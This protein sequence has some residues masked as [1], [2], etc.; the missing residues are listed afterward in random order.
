MKQF[1]LIIIALIATILP[2]IANSQNLD[3]IAVFTKFTKEGSDVVRL[4]LRWLKPGFSE[5]KTGIQ[6]FRMELGVDKDYKLLNE[7]P[8]K[9]FT[10]EDY[11]KMENGDSLEVLNQKAI[12]D[13]ISKNKASGSVIEKV[14]FAQNLQNEYGFYFL[15]TTRIR[16]VSLSSG[17]EYI[18]KTAVKDRIYSYKVVILND[19]KSNRFGVAQITTFEDYLPLSELVATNDEKAVHFKWVQ[20]EEMNP[21][22]SYNLEK[23]ADGVQFKPI[24]NAPFY[25]SPNIS[26]T[27]STDGSEL[28]INFTTDSVA[29]NYKPNFYRLVG[30]DV[31]GEEHISE[32]IVKAMGVDK[33]PVPA[34]QH[35][36]T[37][38][39]ENAKSITFTWNL[40][41]ETD[42]KGFYVYQS[43][44]VKNDYRKVGEDLLAKNQRSFTIQNAVPDLHYYIKLATIDTAGNEEISRMAHGYLPDIYPPTAPENLFAKIDTTGKLILSWNKHP[45]HNLNGFRI[46]TTNRDG[47]KWIQVNQRFIADTFFVDTLN[48]NSLLEKKYYTVIAVDA[49]FN[50][51]PKAARI[52]VKLPDLVGPLAPAFESLTAE[53]EKVMMHISPSGS[54]DVKEVLVYRRQAGQSE[55]T[56]TNSLSWNTLSFNET[57]TEGSYEY[58][59]AAR[60]S[61]GNEGSKSASY[62][63]DLKLVEAKITFKNFEVKKQKTG[64]AL[65]WETGSN[66]K[67]YIVY[68]TEG[69]KVEKIAVVTTGKYVDNSAEK[70]KN[71][72]LSSI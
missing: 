63:I 20:T 1:K 2:A 23:S 26:Q 49:A 45:D 15:I 27:D 54:K 60:D 44:D 48:L 30:I 59:L 53:G 21:I 24:N 11:A 3:S 9:P 12:F 10:K 39:D 14:R 8:L 4:L 64:I 68:R 65:N 31:W 33:T 51:S 18:D 38:I 7:K 55:W 69:K 32:Q 5:Q 52:E 66:A 36:E 72:T 41:D 42:L 40:T 22:I 28:F 47:G 16:E 61:S 6:I 70:G 43:N 58:A 34:P 67:N 57:L 19:K 37:S 29:E 25:F 50:N 35:F 13:N 56:L 46:F 62:F 71:Y 17:L